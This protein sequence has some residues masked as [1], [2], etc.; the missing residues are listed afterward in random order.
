MCG[1][2]RDPQ[3]GINQARLADIRTTHKRDLGLGYRAANR[4]PESA[5]DELRAGDLHLAPRPI[6]VFWQA[7]MRFP[8][9]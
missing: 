5:L 6:R 4:P 7:A 8:A 1:P 9:A 2:N 3:K